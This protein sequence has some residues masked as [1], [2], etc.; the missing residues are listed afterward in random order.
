MTLAN[1]KKN[2][3][4]TNSDGKKEIYEYQIQEDTFKFKFSKV[5]ENYFLE[6]SSRVII[7]IQT[8]GNHIGS[9]LECRLYN[10]QTLDAGS[11]IFK[12]YDWQTHKFK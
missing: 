1:N 2:I 5:E 11:L 10:E 7:G 6:N 3:W 4:W 12:S 9:K 8:K